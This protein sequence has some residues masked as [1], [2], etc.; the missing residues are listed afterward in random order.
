MKKM[1]KMVLLSAMA[2]L[3][4]GNVL[5]VAAATPNTANYSGYVKK[6]VDFES[7]TLQKV[8]LNDDATNK[9]EIID[10]GSWCCWI[11]NYLGM[12]I[13][14]KATFKGPGTVYM[15]YDD[16]GFVGTTHL[17]ISTTI[18]NFSSS[19][20]SGVWSPDYF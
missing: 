6:T 11:E 2:A 19:Y 3:F 8:N 14:N 15:Q 12:R 7:D 18:T 1:K 13:T 20:V 17:V 16:G 4:L 10:E 9:V 5:A